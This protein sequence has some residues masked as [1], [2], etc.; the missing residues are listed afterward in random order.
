MSCETDP[1]LLVAIMRHAYDNAQDSF[2]RRADLEGRRLERGI[3]EDRATSI[4]TFPI[5][6]AIA[7]LSVS[8]GAH[9]V[10]AVALQLDSVNEKIR[11][12]IAGNQGVPDYLKAHI[13]SVWGKLQELSSQYAE[14]RGLDPNIERSPR[15]PKGVAL[16]LRVALFRDICQFSLGKLV[17]RGEKWRTGLSH[18][19]RQL[20]K[21]RRAG[22][23][24]FELN[25]F[26]ST[27]GL[28]QLQKALRELYLD[29]DK[30]LTDDQWVELH[31]ESMWA[32]RCTQRVLEHDRGEGCEKLA[33]MLA[34]TSLLT[35]TTTD[36]QIDRQ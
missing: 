17:A 27:V 12:T 25:L 23:Q 28:L 15:I 31:N 3:T 16:P 11:L 29:S 8:K 1:H 21:R 22:L 24:G 10:Y 4:R 14:N 26:H 20:G 34:G 18:F 5:L 7:S 35:P 19:M 32:C 33:K 13:A 30:K 6:D 2:P 36:S 9:E